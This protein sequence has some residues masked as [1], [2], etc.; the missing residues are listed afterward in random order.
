M[1]A[2]APIPGA[3]DNAAI[4]SLEKFKLLYFYCWDKRNATYNVTDYNG[5]DKLNLLYI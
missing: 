4:V 3:V 1:T 2:I 5:C